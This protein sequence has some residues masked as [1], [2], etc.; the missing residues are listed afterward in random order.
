MYF[1]E[2]TCFSCVERGYFKGGVVESYFVE[3][4][5]NNGENRP[6]GVVAA[7]LT[8]FDRIAGNPLLI[9][10]PLLLDLYLWFGPH[11]NIS[12]FIEQFMTEVYRS[13]GVESL[14]NEQV[15]LVQDAMSIL[16]ER[17]NLF[18][19]LS[20]LPAGM[21]FN[22]MFAILAS[23][24]V[25]LPSLMALRMP[26]TTPL[27]SPVA[28]D[29]QNPTLVIIFWCVFGM[30]G[31][32]LGGLY[33]RNLAKQVA[34]MARFVSAIKMWLRLLALAILGYTLLIILFGTAVILGGESGVMFVALPLAFI[35]GMYL[36]FTPHGIVR[37]RFGILRAIKESIRLVRWNFLSAASYIFLAFMIMWLSTSQ[38]WILPDEDSWFMLLAILGHAFLSATLLVGSYAFFQSRHAA[39][40]TAKSV[41]S[42]MEVGEEP[43]KEESTDS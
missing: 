8:G 37:Y 7:L 5:K 25:G 40:A 17:Y 27:G 38:V 30:V 23:F 43:V 21:P 13:P 36:A 26:I 15:L 4:T 41:E 32:G 10:P 22:I 31:L 24:L 3:N 33:H 20:S 12:T 29:L 14:S 19:N 2:I 34:P 11:L 18:S 39:L 1:L 42:T 16:A 28:Y 9:V 35:A 6:I